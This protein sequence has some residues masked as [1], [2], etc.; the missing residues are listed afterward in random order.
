[1]PFY[2]YR[3]EDCNKEFCILHSMSEQCSEC[4]Y[5]LSENVV[6][7]VSQVESRIDNSKFKKKVGDLVVSHIEEAKEMVANQKK[8]MKK[9]Y[10]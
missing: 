7:I 5:C 6:K 10:K 1:M 9:E 8:D 2:D 4:G 3:C